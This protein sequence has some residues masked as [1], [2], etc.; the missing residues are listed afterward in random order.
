MKLPAW[1]ATRPAWA[2]RA[3]V[4][5]LATRK[6]AWAVLAV[7]AVVAGVTG[8][9]LLRPGGGTRLT[10]ARPSRPVAAPKAPANARL[11]RGFRV[12]VPSIGTD[13]PVVPEGATGP[14]GGALDVPTDVHV[15][16]WWDGIWKSPSGTVREK[17]AAPGQSGVA[18]LAGHVDSAVQGHGV[19]YR[20]AKARP[21]AEVTVIDAHQKV[22]HWK[23]TRIQTVAKSAL[24]AAL[25]VDKGKPQLAL[26]SCGGPFDSATG[27]YLDNVIAW[28]VPAA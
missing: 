24:P 18:L 9:L 22:T 21:G 10:P 1:A 23:V 12:I 28:A 19:F 20:L 15:V 17:V 11:E 14:D 7:I 8:G 16:G 5:A 4:A 27:H 25:F 13:A 2:T 26:V 3:N 6:P